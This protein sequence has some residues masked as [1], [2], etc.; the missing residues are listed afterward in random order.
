MRRKVFSREYNI[1]QDAQAVLDNNEINAENA[2]QNYQNLLD[3]YEKLVRQSERLL[4]MGDRMQRTLTTLNTE[5]SASEQRFRGIF[6]NATEGIYRTDAHGTLLE[7]NTALATMLGYESTGELLRNVPE[8]GSMFYYLGAYHQYHT[9]LHKSF[10]VKAMQVKLCCANGNELWV[11]I[12]AGAIEGGADEECRVSGIVGVIADITERKRMMREMCR[13]ART[14]SLT[15]LWNRG[16]FIELASSEL[17][18]CKRCIRNLSILLVDIDHFKKVNDTYGH[19][20]G[21][22][23]LIGAADTMREALRDID[24]IARFGGEEFVVLLPDTSSRGALKVAERVR[25]AVREQNF[26]YDRHRKI[27]VTVSIGVTS[28]QDAQSDLDLLLKHADIAMYSAKENGRDRVEQC[29]VE[30]VVQPVDENETHNL[31]QHVVHG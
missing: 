12:N 17:A 3:E 22:K 31:N 10:V 20:I 27:T 2:E 14:D 11:E 19:D 26:S 18:R 6:E 8:I 30:A 25:N 1:I 7:V 16:Y 5:L 24:I 4:K 15:G 28:Y 9:V 23:V 21:D 29:L 13:L